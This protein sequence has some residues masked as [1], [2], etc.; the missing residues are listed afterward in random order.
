MELHPQN[1]KAIWL[2]FAANTIS[3]IAQG[4]SMLAIPWYLIAMLN[5]GT[6]FAKALASFTFISVFWSVY[7]GSII[8]KYNRKKVFVG[9][10][11]FCAI[12]LLGVSLG[13]YYQNGLSKYWVLFILLITQLNYN[14][15]Y[16]A[17]Y[18]F[19]QEIVPAKAY[20]RIVSW[21]EI[22]GQATNVIS[23]AFAAMLLAG[24]GYDKASIFSKWFSNITFEAWPLHQV[25]LLD[26]LTYVLALLLIL[27]MKYLS[28]RKSESKNEI[29]QKNII[30]HIATGFQFLWQQK[31]LL[32]LGLFGYSVFITSLVAFKIIIPGYVKHWLTGDAAIFAIAD[33]FFGLGALLAGIF[34][35]SAFNAK[36]RL[37]G[38]IG[39]LLL[40]TIIYGFFVFSKSPNVLFLGAILL[41][42]SNTGVRILRWTVVFE[43]VDNQIIGR[44]SGVFKMMETLLRTSFILL[45]SLAWFQDGEQIRYGFLVFAIFTLFSALGL[46][47]FYN[48]IKEITHK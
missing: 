42:L 26:G 12:A 8:D 15:H 23:G 24:I 39:L 4:I 32:A 3:G 21:L 35:N 17:L 11:I 1:K 25:F 29:S 10:N 27:P 46:M 45:L 40:V 30:K 44:V 13:G 19:A 37:Q 9:L 28:Q 20:G 31:P 34:I 14:M 22:Q 41:G 33:L 7:A 43:A 47:L 5:E 38:I 2:L 16:P 6:L 18:A 36:S 48:R